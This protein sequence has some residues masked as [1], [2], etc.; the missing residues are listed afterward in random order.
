VTTIDHL[1]ENGGKL[2]EVVGLPQVIGKIWYYRHSANELLL[3]SYTSELKT[4]V[5]ST[6]CTE[7]NR[8]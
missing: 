6:D 8:L 3:H 7:D 2:K 4:A 5:Q 1:G